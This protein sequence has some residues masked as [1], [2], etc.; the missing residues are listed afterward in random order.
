[1]SANAPQVVSL[2]DL[3][4]ASPLTAADLVGRAF[5]IGRLEWRTLLVP[6]FVPSFF[7]VA[8]YAYGSWAVG[9]AGYPSAVILNLI[10]VALCVVVKARVDV[11][12][13]SYAVIDV[14][15]GVAPN[16]AEAKRNAGQKWPMIT[17]LMIPSTLSDALLLVLTLVAGNRFAMLPATPGFDVETWITLALACCIVAAALPGVTLYVINTS[18]VATYAAEDRSILRALRRCFVLASGYWHYIFI[19]FL[20]SSLA[21]FCIEGAAGFTLLIS[22]IPD[23]FSGYTKEIV[24]FAIETICCL[25]QAPLYALIFLITA[26]CGALLYSQLKMRLECSD[27][28]DQLAKLTVN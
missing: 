19:F 8:G 26:V 17:L 11:S 23:R 5:R 1:M 10:L 2:S 14:L 15:I 7:Y 20:L 18:F 4:P 3:V 13:V 27:L 9:H 24:T 25:V 28:R 22:W 12:V 21:L 16:F 6:F